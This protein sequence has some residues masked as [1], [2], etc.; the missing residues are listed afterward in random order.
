MCL[1]PI[2]GKDLHSQSLVELRLKLDDS[3]CTPFHF[4]ALYEAK[5]LAK[6]FD[7]ILG[8]SP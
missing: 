7:G 8:L 1:N 2:N 5:G 3:K 6:D 4:V